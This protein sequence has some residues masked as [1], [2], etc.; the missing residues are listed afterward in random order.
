MNTKNIKSAA[1]KAVST[2]NLPQP[3]SVITAWLVLDGKEY[4]LKSFS[5]EFAQSTDY[6]GQPQAEV[7]GG[8]L[9]LSFF[10]LPDEN[11]NRWMLRTGTSGSKSGEIQFRKKTSNMPLRI[12]F[13]DAR[14][15][16]Y[17]KKL[18][19]SRTGFDVKIVISPKE[20]TFNEI[21][22]SNRWR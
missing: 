4:E 14:C 7:K 1:E 6:K 18:G 13:V 16:N 19:S 11:I 22:H 12:N 21:L 17:Q 3:E 10:Q 8:L 9:H 15:I 20:I 5:T 2:F